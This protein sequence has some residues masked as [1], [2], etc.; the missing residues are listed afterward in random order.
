VVPRQEGRGPT[1]REL[2]A[3]RAPARTEI[4]ERC[5]RLLAQL[6]K[7]CPDALPPDPIEPST[8]APAITLKGEELE[9]LVRAALA[10]ADGDPAVVLVDGDSELVVH[11]QR[12][13]LAVR[14]GLVLVGLTVECDQTGRVEVVVPFAVGVPDRPA[15][16]VAVTETRPRGPDV[17]VRR[18]GDALTALAWRALLDVATGISR[19]AGADLDAAPLVP[20]ALLAEDGALAVVPQARHSFDRTGPG[21]GSEPGSR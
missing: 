11:L 18:W 1:L 2:L 3:T 19:H 15:G 12:T 10:G 20:G 5:K 16:L 9:G 13:R 6:R 21:L 4:D 8:L 14:V 7:T 17:I